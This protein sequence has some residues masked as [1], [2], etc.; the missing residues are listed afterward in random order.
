MADGV[1]SPDA[2]EVVEQDLGI[3]LTPGNGVYATDGVYHAYVAFMRP[4]LNQDGTYSGP[5]LLMVVGDKG[6]KISLN[7]KVEDVVEEKRLRRAYPE[8]RGSFDINH[9]LLRQ[10]VVDLT[11][12]EIRATPRTITED[13]INLRVESTTGRPIDQRMIPVPEHGIEEMRLVLTAMAQ[14]SST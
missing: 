13:E 14:K 1:S 9:V 8:F 4:F 3:N 10:S 11:T 6:E 12:A 5:A 7:K 2:Q